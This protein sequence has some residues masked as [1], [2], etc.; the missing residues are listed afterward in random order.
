MRENLFTILKCFSVCCVADIAA[1]VYVCTLINNK[2]YTKFGRGVVFKIVSCVT[3]QT[4][5]QATKRVVASTAAPAKRGFVPSGDG[6]DVV[7]R[8]I[9]TDKGGAVGYRT[10]RSKWSVSATS[11]AYNTVNPIRRIIEQ[12]KI[13]PNPEKFMIPLSIGKCAKALADP[14]GGMRTYSS[15]PPEF[16]EKKEEKKTFIVESRE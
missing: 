13:E 9:G 14:G 15:P 2:N 1:T 11:F 6:I 16:S 5:Q 7:D 3:M 8:A 4:D 10:H 12:L